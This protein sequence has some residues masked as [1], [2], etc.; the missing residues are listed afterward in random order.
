MTYGDFQDLPRKT[1][2]DKVWHQRGITSM[3]YKLFDRKQALLADKSV[4][5]SGVKK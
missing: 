3:V 1:V 4:S 5:G 2:S